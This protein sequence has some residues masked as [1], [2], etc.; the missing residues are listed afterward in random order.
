MTNFVC[1]FNRQV[2][3]DRLKS[4]EDIQNLIG[5]VFANKQRI[6][7]DDFKKITA[8]TCSDMFLC[9]LILLQDSLPCTENFIRYQKNFEKYMNPDD[10]KAK[11]DKE[12]TVKVIRSPVLLPK[13][14][15]IRGLYEK[16]GVN[17]NP[18][19]QKDM[20]KYAA[21]DPGAGSAAAAA[22]KPTA[23]QSG[24]ANF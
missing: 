8:D 18:D 23:G 6:N 22:E 5:V 13:H 7:L 24:Q 2:F 1:G 12:E 14:S 17:M 19:S 16:I 10:Q 21:N 3:L 4:Q 11:G 15:P 9:I 20:L